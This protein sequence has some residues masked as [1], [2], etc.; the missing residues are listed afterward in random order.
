MKVVLD[1]NILFSA[2]TRDSFIRRIILEYE[3]RFLFPDLIFEELE[4]RRRELQEKSGLEEEEFGLL[5]ELL[6][7]KVAI[8]PRRM[9]LPFREEA[10]LAVKDIDPDDAIFAACVLAY[11]GSILWSDDK[12]LKKQNKIRVADS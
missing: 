10:C 9:L 3:G 11:P 5:L 12:S 7:T 8:V 4:E 6:L 2:L 1:L